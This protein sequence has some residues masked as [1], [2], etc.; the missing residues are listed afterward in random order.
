ME[1]TLKKF[2]N[3]L[4]STFWQIRETLE[5]FNTVKSSLLANRKF[6]YALLE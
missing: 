3:I 2:I 5:A 1:L 6:I 4:V